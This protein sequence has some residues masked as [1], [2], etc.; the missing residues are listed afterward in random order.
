MSDRSVRHPTSAKKGSIPREKSTLK[1][2]LV[3]TLLSRL[4]LAT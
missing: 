2:A 4:L 3:L 1:K